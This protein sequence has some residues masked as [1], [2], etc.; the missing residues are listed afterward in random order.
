MV[1]AKK[2]CMPNGRSP[3]RGKE[4][5]V[6]LLDAAASIFQ[7]WKSRKGGPAADELDTEDQEDNELEDEGE[8][9]EYYYR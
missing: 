5:L 3:L 6:V 9:V 7:E 2:L 8:E 1:T 4:E